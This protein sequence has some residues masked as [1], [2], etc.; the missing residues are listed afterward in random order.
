MSSK[1]RPNIE[2]VAACGRV[3]LEA[4]HQYNLK[5]G[6]ICY[7]QFTELIEVATAYFIGYMDCIIGEHVY[8]M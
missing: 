4:F 7:K 2:A 3:A 6:S 1:I 8:Q 5:R